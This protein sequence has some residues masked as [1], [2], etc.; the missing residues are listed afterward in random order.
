MQRSKRFAVRSLKRSGLVVNVKMKSI[1]YECPFNQPT[2]LCYVREIIC[3]MQSRSWNILTSV[4]WL[5][6]PKTT[7]LK[8]KS[9]EALGS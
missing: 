6:I 7:F 8:I 1:T 2:E 3:R 9:A 4:I 5:F